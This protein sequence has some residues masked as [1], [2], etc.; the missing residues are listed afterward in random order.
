MITDGNTPLGIL[1][2]LALIGGTLVAGGAIAFGLAKGHPGLVR[3]STG[4]LLAGWGGYAALLLIASLAS[5]ERVLER[6]QEKHICEIDCHTAYTVMNVQSA[7]T[8]GDRTAS[9]GGMFTVVTL[10]VRFDSATISSRRG[11]AP[12]TPGGRVVEVVARD[13]RRFPPLPADPQAIPLTKQLVPGESYTTTLVFDL[14]TDV[15][16]PRL[17]IAAAT[18]LPDRF[19]IGYENSLLHSKTTFRLGA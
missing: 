16:E 7:K 9:E 3:F 10:R 1:A 8:Y 15:A 17:V 6:G 12:L 5:R 19:I 4:A 11:M 18:G 13:G 2:L 14:P